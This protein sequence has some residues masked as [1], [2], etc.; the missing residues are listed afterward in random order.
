MGITVGRPGAGVKVQVD[1]GLMDR[2]GGLG[3]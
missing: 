1:T 2:M 3:E